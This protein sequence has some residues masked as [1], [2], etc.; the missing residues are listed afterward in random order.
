MRYIATLP[1]ATVGRRGAKMM[2][3][4]SAESPRVGLTLPPTK[5]RDLS[6]LYVHRVRAE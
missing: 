6:E 5:G 1:V 2:S 3:Y 4:G